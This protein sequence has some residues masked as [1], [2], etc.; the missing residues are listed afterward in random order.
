M[1]ITQ[2]QVVHIDSNTCIESLQLFSRTEPLILKNAIQDWPALRWTIDS[3]ADRL[4]N[5]LLTTS[6]FTQTPLKH[7]IAWETD[8]KRFQVRLKDFSNWLQNKTSSSTTEQHPI[9]SKFDKNQYW[10]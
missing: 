4:E 6:F 5:T 7:Q 2:V 8:Q 3:L 9:F 1:N 10:G